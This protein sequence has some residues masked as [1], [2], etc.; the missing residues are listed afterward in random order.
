MSGVE[1]NEDQYDGKIEEWQSENDDVDGDKSDKMDWKNTNIG[2]HP[3]QGS[4]VYPSK[5]VGFWGGWG[6]RLGGK[7]LISIEER[8]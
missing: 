8:A 1:W 4:W 5:S 6:R 3:I 2:T 7:R